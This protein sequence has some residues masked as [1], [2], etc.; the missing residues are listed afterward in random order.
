M[1]E[2]GKI[3]KL[4]RE[5]KY[6]VLL[7]N[8]NAYNK[9]RALLKES[10]SLEEVQFQINEAINHS[11]TTGS[12]INAYEHMWGYFKNIATDN[13]KHKALMLKDDFMN[14]QIELDS[15]LSYLSQLANKYDI[16]YLQE[17]TVL[18]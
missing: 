1:K 15:L 14:H 4:W 18:N 12:I 16:K 2:R 8:Q 5:E 17:S 13:E 11:P 10:P 3:E 7:H 6:R 9:I